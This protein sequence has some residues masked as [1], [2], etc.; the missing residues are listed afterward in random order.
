MKKV[1]HRKTSVELYLPADKLGLHI[2]GGAI[3]PTQKASVTT[4]YRYAQ[5]KTQRGHAGIL[6]DHKSLESVYPSFTLLQKH[7]N[8]ATKVFKTS[9]YQ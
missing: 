7:T 6:K 1:T 3:L 5:Q 9:V 2:R 8:I 4:T